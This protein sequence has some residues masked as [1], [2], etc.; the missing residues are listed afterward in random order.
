MRTQRLYPRYLR[1]EFDGPS[2]TLL[3][4][5]GSYTGPKVCLVLELAVG[6]DLMGLLQQH[7]GRGITAEPAR[8][9]L[10]GVC[11]GAEYLHAVC[12]VVHCDLKPENVLLSEAGEPKLCDFDATV[13]SGAVTELRG[14]RDYLAPELLPSPELLAARRAA[15]GGHTGKSTTVIEPARDIWAIGL[16]AFIVW[17]GARYTLCQNPNA[18]LFVY[19]WRPPARW[20]TRA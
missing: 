12:G 6:G 11:A 9:V 16:I 1:E 13:P 19:D 8:K 4:T 7:A 5:A 10:T 17:T 18:R 2:F 20:R 15:P 3:T 14:T